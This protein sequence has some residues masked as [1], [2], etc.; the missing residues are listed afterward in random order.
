MCNTTYA[1]FQLNSYSKGYHIDNTHKK[2]LGKKS[3]ITNKLTRI[4]L[5]QFNNIA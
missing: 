4:F 3:Y 5:K 2:K 1:L